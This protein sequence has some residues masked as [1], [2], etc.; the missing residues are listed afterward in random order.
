MMPEDTPDLLRDQPC[1]DC[2]FTPGTQ[3]NLYKWTA[4][5]AELCVIARE[6]FWCHKGQKGGEPKKLCLGWAERVAFGPEHPEWRKKFADR[7]LRFLERVED[8]EIPKESQIKELYSAAL[9]DSEP[10]GSTK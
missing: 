9:G 3:A 5:K 2:A 8:G 1:S 4:S 6:P 7:M 10:E